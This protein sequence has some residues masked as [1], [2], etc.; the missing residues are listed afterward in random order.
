MKKSRKG[1]KGRLFIGERS[2]TEWV[3]RESRSLEGRIAESDCSSGLQRR[4]CN[5]A[6]GW[7][8]LHDEIDLITSRFS[9]IP[10]AAIA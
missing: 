7:P 3:H 10:S 2:G 5:C 9:H 4:K 8:K 6:N 1:G